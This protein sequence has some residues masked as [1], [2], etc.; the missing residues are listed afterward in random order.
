MGQLNLFSRWH[1]RYRPWQSSWPLWKSWWTCARHALVLWPGWSW[2]KPLSWSTARL[3]PSDPLRSCAAPPRQSQECQDYSPITWSYW[4]VSR[5]LPQESNLK[6]SCVWCQVPSRG[7]ERILCEYRCWEILIPSF[8]QMIFAN[9]LWQH[10]R[11]YKRWQGNQEE[12]PLLQNTLWDETHEEY[13]LW[14]E[15]SGA[16][17]GWIQ[18]KGLIE[19]HERVPPDQDGRVC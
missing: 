13:N 4:S 12:R 6:H 8:W 19:R 2:K 5:L 1:E 17:E 16:V 9:R 10:T 11:T 18:D 7:G 15:V 14:V 3:R